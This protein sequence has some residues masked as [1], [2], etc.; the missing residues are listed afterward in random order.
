MSKAKMSPKMCQ[1]SKLCKKVQNVVW[2]HY[3]FYIL[4]TGT[5][6]NLD[7]SYLEATKMQVF[8]A[9]CLGCC[10]GTPKNCES[11]VPGILK[12]TKGSPNAS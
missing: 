8:S 12:A 4:T 10:P 5:F 9:W 6:Q 7:F 11:G 2:A 1:K 3:F